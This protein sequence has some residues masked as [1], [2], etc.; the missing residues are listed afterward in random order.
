MLNFAIYSVVVNASSYKID[1]IYKAIEAYGL[2]V[3]ELTGVRRISEGSYECFGCF[4]KQGR[5][6]S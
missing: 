1:G 3:L 2:Y 4:I 6:G 5:R